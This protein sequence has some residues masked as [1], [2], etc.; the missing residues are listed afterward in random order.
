MIF[1]KVVVNY[2]VVNMI[3]KSSHVPVILK[4]IRK[5]VL[6]TMNCNIH[7]VSQNVPG[8]LNCISDL[9]SRSVDHFNGIVSILVIGSLSL[10]STL[11]YR[12]NLQQFLKF[13]VSIDCI[14]NS[15]PANVSHIL[16]F[17]GHLFSNGNN[18]F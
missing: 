2:S 10:S 15:L 18:L 7:F 17:I 14:F 11:V 9:L 12:K 8:K 6:Q 1:L 3:N 4:L 16:Y 13:C 5:M